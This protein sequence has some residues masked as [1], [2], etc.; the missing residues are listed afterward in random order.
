[1][2]P[3]SPTPVHTLCFKLADIPLNPSSLDGPSIIPG[4]PRIIR[5]AS[6]VQNQHRSQ[7]Q[8]SIQSSELSSIGP[9]SDI[10]KLTASFR[11]RP[12]TP[13]INLLK[14]EDK[15]SGAIVDIFQNFDDFV[16]G[17]IERGED[18]ESETDLYLRL[19]KEYLNEDVETIKEYK[20]IDIVA[21]T[22]NLS[23]Q[24]FGSALSQL[25]ELK[26]NG[27]VIRSIRD[28]GTTFKSLKVLWVSRVGL[29]DLSGIIP[30][31]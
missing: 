16:R 30:F 1:M 9:P 24:A 10:K 2:E 15:E 4:E 27:S 26:L 31:S 20:K 25:L 19:L 14:K 22:S 13:K 23:L 3:H 8:E 5:S 18:V 29:K 17:L 28:I 11:I 7:Q 21:D 6:F 12:A